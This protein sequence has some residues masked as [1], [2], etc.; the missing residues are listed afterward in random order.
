MPA[1][2][3]VDG[4]TYKVTAIANNAFAGNKK[5]TKVTIGKYVKTIGKKAFQGCSALKNMVVKTNNLKTVGK[6][7]LKGTN[8]K[9]FIKVPSKK[10]KNYKKYF[11]GKGNKKVKVK[12]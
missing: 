12:K 1:T 10:L 8:K 4:V 5:I 2:V 9:L 11:K 7:A 6:N 3:T